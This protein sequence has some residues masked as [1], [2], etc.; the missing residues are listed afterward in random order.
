M[1]K[2]IKSIKA[3][4]YFTDKML[5]M[6][7]RVCIISI[8]ETINPNNSRKGKKLYGSKTVF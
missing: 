5:K 8:S 1:G 3:R 4:I 7:L 6:P 2:F